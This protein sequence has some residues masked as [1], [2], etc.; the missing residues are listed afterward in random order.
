MVQWAAKKKKK[1]KQ[2]W[3]T[4]LFPKKIQELLAFIVK[5]LQFFEDVDP[6]SQ[7]FSKVMHAYPED[8]SP[9]GVM[10]KEVDCGILVIEFELQSRCYIHFRTNTLGKSIN[11]LIL[12]AMG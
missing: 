3:A 2:T 6:N 10:V 7:P 5:Q 11:P 4:S 1:K 8:F 9:Y 12:P